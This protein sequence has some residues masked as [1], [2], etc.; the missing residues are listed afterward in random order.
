MAIYKEGDSG[1]G[2]PMLGMSEG[3]GRTS[4]TK[5]PT[6]TIRNPIM[7]MG[8]YYNKF[9]GWSSSHTKWT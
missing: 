9:C 1:M 5:W 6:T 2:E 3:E 7:E 8:A 4:A